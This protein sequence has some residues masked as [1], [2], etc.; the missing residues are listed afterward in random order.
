MFNAMHIYQRYISASVRGQLQYRTSFVMRTIAHLLITGG[1]FLMVWALF[2][3]FGRLGQ[4]RLAEV[5]ML[6]G[7]VNL[8]YAISESICRGLENVGQMVRR[9]DFDRL[10]LR[11]RTLMLQL[12]GVEL[13][14]VVLFGR[15]SQACMVLGWAISESNVA[16]TVTKLLLL[17]FV[18]AG[19]AC[20]FLG[21][22][23]LQATWSFWT[24]ES[25]EVMEVLAVGGT[26]AAQYPMS[27]YK[28]WLRTALTF[29]VPLACVQYY[30][31]ANLLDMPDA[32]GV[33][34]WTS[35]ISPT[36]G[37]AFLLVSLAI[38]RIGVRHYTSTG[39]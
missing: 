35:W 1:E 5:A 10:M 29:I 2:H 34:V 32:V 4:W 30:P 21:I 36:A 24:I 16:W 12:F 11:P 38:W 20:V 19:C 39:S 25:L 3:R 22:R 18:I 26:E 31:L 27:I 23:V 14:L 6:Y 33:P 13:R 8:G 37:P 9:G 17:V 7:T 15:G 28:P